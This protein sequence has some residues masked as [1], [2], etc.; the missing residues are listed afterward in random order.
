MSTCDPKE[1]AVASGM[2]AVAG[3]VYQIRRSSA[4]SPGMST[5]LLLVLSSCRTAFL[6]S[7]CFLTRPVRTERQL[8]QVRKKLS[9]GLRRSPLRLGDGE[10][11]PRAEP[12]HVGSFKQP[13]AAQ[14]FLAFVGAGPHLPGT[15]FAQ[16]SCLSLLL[17]RVRDEDMLLF[18]VHW[19]HLQR[20]FQFHKCH[21]GCALCL[22][23]L[24]FHLR[25]LLQGKKTEVMFLCGGVNVGAVPWQWGS[26]PLRVFPGSGQFPCSLLSFR[27]AA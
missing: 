12:P 24:H 15:W 7:R 19:H 10:A 8:Q 11:K 3:E 26:R 13:A 17:R 14:L 16:R 27:K 2:K 21:G 20:L 25:L 5:A 4:V 18:H 1:G 9:G 23:P 22:Q 6:L